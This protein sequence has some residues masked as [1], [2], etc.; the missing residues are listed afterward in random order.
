MQANPQIRKFAHWAPLP[1]LAG[2]LAVRTLRQEP[3][4]IGCW[5]KN[6]DNRASRICGLPYGDAAPGKACVKG[7]W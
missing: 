4:H 6:N 5:R 1:R 2:A 7:G 3:R